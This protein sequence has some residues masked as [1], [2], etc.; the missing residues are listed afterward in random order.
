M[1]P[2]LLPLQSSLRVDSSSIKFGQKF[3]LLARSSLRSEPCKLCLACWT[4]AFFAILLLLVPLQ[5]SLGSES[6][7][8]HAPMPLPLPSNIS[9]FA[10]LMETLCFASGGRCLP[11]MMP[12]LRVFG[13][14]GTMSVESQ[15]DEVADSKFGFGITDGS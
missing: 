1:L 6:S 14:L 9:D 15:P 2:L 11:R 12:F 4:Q 7:P 3:L 8:F 10:L 13:I 5:S